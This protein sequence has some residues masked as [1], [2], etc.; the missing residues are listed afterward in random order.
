MVCT[1]SK[2]AAV[3][4]AAAYVVAGWALERDWRFALTV[5]LGALPPLALIWFP[6]FLGDFTRWGGRS[7]SVSPSPHKL[8]ALM[9]W[10]LLVG[11][12]LL[13]LAVSTRG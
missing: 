9:G 6:E 4:V 7:P 5:A 12:P 8:V 11:I 3:F 10:V 1:I 13:V 2:V